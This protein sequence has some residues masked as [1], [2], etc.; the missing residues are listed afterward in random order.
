VQTPSLS[1]K[2]VAAQ[3]VLAAQVVKQS[4]RDCPARLAKMRAKSMVIPFLEMSISMRKRTPL[5]VRRVLGVEG[6]AAPEV[7]VET[8]EEVREAEPVGRVELLPAPPVTER[9]G[10]AEVELFP[11]PPVTPAGPVALA[12]ELPEGRATPVEEVPA[13]EVP[14]KTSEVVE[15]EALSW[16]R[17]KS[18]PG[19]S[20]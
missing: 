6:T 2:E 8:P 10:R 9:V 17:A 4:S 20:A 12:V 1:V 7:V 3:L 14:L 16:T 11:A 5:M 19:V 13:E 15:L 18:V